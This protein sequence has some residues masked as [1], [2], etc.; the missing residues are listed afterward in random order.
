MHSQP[1]QMLRKAEDLRR[2]SQT[3]IQIYQIYA[4]FVPLAQSKKILF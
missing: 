3:G 2:Q 1:M 4:L